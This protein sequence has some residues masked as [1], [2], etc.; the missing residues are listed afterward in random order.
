MPLFT[1]PKIQGQAQMT[2]TRWGLIGATTIGK[3]WMVDA[4]R[5]AG[6]EVV[7]VYSR[8]AGRGAAY[9]AEC[10]ISKS[11]TELRALL[12]DVDAVYIATTNERHHDECLASAAAGRHVLCEKPLA[13]SYRAAE[14][15]VAACRAAGVVMGT[16]HHLRNAATH[17]AMRKLIGEGG[18]GRPL[19]AHVVHAA[20]LPLHL[21]GWRLK[22]A[23][24]GAGAIFDLTVH[25]ADLLRFVLADEPDRIS[26]MSQN[27]GLAE[28]GI[29]DAA[30]SVIA[31]RTGLLAQIHDGF[32]LPYVQTSFAV[33]GS[34][35][36]VIATDCMAQRPGGKVVVRDARGERELP[37]DQENYYVRGLHAFHAAIVGE[38]APSATG[39]DG[40][41]SLAVTLAARQSAAS[42]QAVAVDAAR[43]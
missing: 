20:A 31:F 27:G 33:H 36:S 40:L 39:E 6:G 10:G 38:G 16:N 34:E 15:M 11:T 30:M 28:A 1:K 25:D 26:T 41:V 7:S 5:Q 22:D 12:A 2:V 14:D 35:G 4:I 3:E 21:H 17:R 18:I 43:L 13:T 23:G 24:A 32:T 9:A 29:E 19:A 42:G 37:L 8:D